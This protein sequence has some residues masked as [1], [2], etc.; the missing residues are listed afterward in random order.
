MHTDTYAN[1]VFRCYG[2]SRGHSAGRNGNS[3]FTAGHLHADAHEHAVWWRTRAYLHAHHLA[4]AV[5]LPRGDL[6]ADCCAHRYAL[7]LPRG[8]LHA[9]AYPMF[10]GPYAH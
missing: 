9:D 1:T 3:Y 8:D 2:H 4:H 5:R 10:R 7:W 6:Y